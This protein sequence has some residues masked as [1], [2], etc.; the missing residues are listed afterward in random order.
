MRF[1]AALFS[2][3]VSALTVLEAAPAWGNSQNLASFYEKSREL[4]DGA[5]SIATVADSPTAS[6]K[7]VLRL[8]G[9]WSRDE[10]RLRGSLTRYRTNSR[11]DRRIVQELQRADSYVVDAL[12][13]T[14]AHCNRPA[15]KED[16][17][18]N[19]DPPHLRCG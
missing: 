18:P 7:S 11:G 16:A 2:L 12:D 10:E 3:G 8:H 13:A 5:Q 9:F 4:V 19:T 14:I 6:H 17:E 15:A 1:A